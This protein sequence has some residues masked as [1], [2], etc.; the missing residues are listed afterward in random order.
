MAALREILAQFGVKFDQASVAKADNSIQGLVEKVQGF[1]TAAAAALGVNAV[2]GFILD[3]V[4]QADALGD[5]SAALGVNAQVLQSWKYAAERA[6]GSGDAVVGALAKIQKQV[7][8]SPEGFKDL[9]IEVK[10]AQGEL[11]GAAELF[12]EA[13]AAIAAIENPTEQA[14]KASKVFGRS[15]L[16]IIP[17]LKQGP[18][19][20][21][22]LRA[23]FAELGGGFDDAFIEKA[24]EID[25]QLK[26]LDVASRSLK[27]QIGSRL[28]PAVTK[29]LDLALRADHTIQG[30]T[31]NTKLL[32]AA[33]AG[34]ALRGAGL[35]SD[36]IG[37][38]GAAFRKLAPQILKTVLPLLLLEDLFVFLSGGDS[39]LGDAFDFFGGSGAQ[40]KVRSF[41]DEVRQSFASFFAGLDSSNKE[42]SS[43]FVED[44][45][46]AMAG[47]ASGDIW[48]QFRKWV[49][50]VTSGHNVIVQ[51]A[52]EAAAGLTEMFGRAFADI[53]SGFSI[54][55]TGLHNDM[56]RLELW[57]AETMQSLQEGWNNLISSLHLPD[58]LKGDTADND[59]AVAKARAKR[60]SVSEGG[61]FTTDADLENLRK[62]AVAMAGRSSSA[63]QGKPIA[64]D[65]IV[66]GGKASVPAPPQVSNTTVHAPTTITNKTT[67]TVPPGTPAE[68]ANAVGRAAE[69]GASKG[70][71]DFRAAQAAL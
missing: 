5:T 39:L 22:K 45:D 21:E 50:G 48:K 42:A 32:E 40:D 36:K 8:E 11:K 34:A 14:A 51:S 30:W 26:D 10:T 35:L 44:W 70:S 41:I 2:K 38:L 43:R 19:G 23:R 62:G 16:D 24:G 69:A 59:A 1:A 52:I 47:F 60:R 6:G 71:E 58:F 54:T 29:L 57:W 9:G 49:D 55:S 25:D 61:E 68:Q 18:E 67:V 31:K 28:L 33:L 15:F 64:L 27:V 7:N 4:D 12:E 37:G 17:L 3:L 53:A 65:E 56:I 20:I 46:I 63:S 66:V 13:A